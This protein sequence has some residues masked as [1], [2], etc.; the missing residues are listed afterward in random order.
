MNHEAGSQP[1]F[2]LNSDPEQIKG[3][4]SFIS[5]VAYCAYILP[6]HLTFFFSL[7]HQ[8]LEKIPKVLPGSWKLDPRSETICADFNEVHI[9][10]S[11]KN[12]I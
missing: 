9:I 3:V 1:P 4:T 2:S 11:Q 10:S 5:V 12:F 8:D 6:S 7:P